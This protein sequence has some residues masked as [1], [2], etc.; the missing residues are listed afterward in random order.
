MFD[1]KAWR[2]KHYEEHREEINKKNR[3]YRKNNIEKS[4]QYRKNNYEKNKK[5]ELEYQKKYYEEHKE[6]IK[7]KGKIYSKD[8]YKKNKN[9]G[10]IVWEQHYEKIPSGYVLIH[11]DNDKNN[12]DLDNLALITKTEYGTMHLKGL[13]VSSNK[14]ITE[15]NILIARL[16]NKKIKIEKGEQTL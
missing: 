14:D 1:R 12:N 13:N 10:I 9:V 11:K 16:M 5:K 15:T 4:K 8:Y 2:K 7:E 3:E 6:E